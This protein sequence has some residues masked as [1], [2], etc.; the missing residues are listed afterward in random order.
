MYVWVIAAIVHVD[1]AAH[2]AV[3]SEQSRE[4][5]SAFSDVMNYADD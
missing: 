4:S 3:Q 1:A 2:C 5:S